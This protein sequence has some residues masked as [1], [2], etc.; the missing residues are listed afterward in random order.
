MK[1]FSLEPTNHCNARCS[2]CPWPTEAHSRVRGF[3][4]METAQ[5][6]AEACTSKSISFA[7]LGEPL[8]HKRLDTIV[9]LFSDKG[10]KTQLNTNGHLLNQSWYDRLCDAGLTRLMVTADYFPWDEDKNIQERSLPIEFQ[11]VVTEIEGVKQ[12]DLD[13]WGGRH[14]SAPREHIECSH[15]SDGWT[16]VQWNGD[17]VR[18]CIDFNGEAVLGNVHSYQEEDFRG[19]TV[20]WCEGCAGYFFKSAMVSGDYTGEKGDAAPPEFLE[21]DADV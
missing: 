11:T 13:D 19:R 6:A 4:S 8:I 10:I 17:I 9:K 3:M 2:F 12:K 7:G 21:I 14:G 1:I 18:C 16:V 15:L 5:R 20:D